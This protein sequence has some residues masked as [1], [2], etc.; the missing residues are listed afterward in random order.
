[1]KIKKIEW[2]GFARRCRNTLDTRTAHIELI[3]KHTF[4]AAT[5]RNEF[6]A[7]LPEQYTHIIWKQ[8]GRHGCSLYLVEVVRV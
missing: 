3:T 8:D 6:I 5:K 2:D 4:S 1:M 7:M